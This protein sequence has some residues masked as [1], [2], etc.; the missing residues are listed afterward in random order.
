MARESRELQIPRPLMAEWTYT[1]SPIAEWVAYFHWLAVGAGVLA[2]IAWGV[3]ASIAIP[4]INAKLE[5]SDHIPELTNALLR[6]ARWNAG[7]AFLTA[8][9]IGAAVAA[10]LLK[11]RAALA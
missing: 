1:V 9:T 6:Q 2:A 11:A 10:E 5:G 7:A 3:A 4:T 8:I